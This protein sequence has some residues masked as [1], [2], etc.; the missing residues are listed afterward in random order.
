LFVG[1]L[2]QWLM[3]VFVPGYFR[4]FV[5]QTGE[6]LTAGTNLARPVPWPWA[7]P[8]LDPFWLRIPLVVE[9]CWYLL[10][11]SFFVLVAIRVWQLGPT[12]MLSHPVLAATTLVSLPY[13]HYVF[14]RPDIVHLSHGAPTAA[15][16]LI[17][18][19]FTFGVGR[20]S[21]GYVLASVLMGAS[22]FAN[23]FQFGLTIEMMAPPN[24]LFA[25]EIKNHRILVRGYYA[26]V[27][28]LAQHLAHDLAKPDEPILFLP[29][30]PGLYPFTGRVSPISR[31]YFVYPSPEEDRAMLSEVEAA[32]VQWVMLQ[33]YALDGRDDL[34]F[35][36]AN[37]L[38]S[39][40]FQRNFG[41]V[42]IPDV[43][44]GFVIL[45]RHRQDFGP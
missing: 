1:Y 19:G 13:T 20:W 39:K 7:T 40:Y 30:M 37:P 9:G 32:K 15:L 17:A 42:N 8:A 41:Q 16:G 21:L 27:L 6:M 43:P 33:D 34:R 26:K 23:L 10:L 29:L 44:P 31:N 3:F 18:L 5:Q 35:K 12:R 24:T 2:A 22:F 4:A 45:R 38:V 14:S 28:L 11:L 25:V 36:N